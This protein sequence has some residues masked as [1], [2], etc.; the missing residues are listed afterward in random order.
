MVAVLLISWNPVLLALYW[1]FGFRFGDWQGM[2]SEASLCGFCWPQ[3]LRDIPV[4]EYS[5]NPY[6]PEDP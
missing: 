5:Q 1:H 2:F 3:Q 4:P 6:S